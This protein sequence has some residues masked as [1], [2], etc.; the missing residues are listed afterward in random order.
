M[1]EIKEKIMHEYELNE[2]FLS[3]LKRLEDGAFAIPFCDSTGEPFGELYFNPTDEAFPKKCILLAEEIK[4]ATSLIKRI[5]IKTDGTA[6]KWDIRAVIIMRRAEAHLKKGFDGLFGY[7][8]FKS[9]FAKRRPCALV[10][11]NFFLVNV[12]DAF[13]SSVFV[14]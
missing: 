7:G 13:V 8:A 4:K 11:G 2:E 6:P 12:L 9:F 1:A 14:E 10:A 3:S 5:H